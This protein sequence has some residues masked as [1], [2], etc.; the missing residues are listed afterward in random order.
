MY[1]FSLKKKKKN[2]IMILIQEASVQFRAEEA[3]WM[4]P[5]M[6]RNNCFV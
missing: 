4:G 6:V 1:L 2:I 3:S 5:N